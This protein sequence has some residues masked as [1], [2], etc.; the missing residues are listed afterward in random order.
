MKKNNKVILRLIRPDGSFYYSDVF[1]KLFLGA[2]SIGTSRIILES[3]KKFNTSLVLK[4]SEKFVI[5]FLH[6]SKTQHQ[7]PN[8]NTLSSIFLESKFFSVSSNW[9]H[10]QISSMNEI[11]LNEIFCKSKTSY[12]SNLI[13]ILSKPF[14]SNIMAAYCSMHS[15][16]SSSISLKL[17]NPQNPILEISSKE[18]SRTS[19]AIKT[20]SS[21]LKKNRKKF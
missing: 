5:P 3:L 18:N 7:W 11:I 8:S 21:E 15:S 2:G 4:D 14:I 17:V 9:L 16:L 6:F 13:G 20:Y 10:T 19:K 1:D 12:D